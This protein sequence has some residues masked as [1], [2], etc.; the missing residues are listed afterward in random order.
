[1][2]L[3]EALI[4]QEFGKDCIIKAEIDYA[5]IVSSASYKALEQ[6]REILDRDDLDDADCFQRIEEIVRVFEAMGSNGGSR[7]DFG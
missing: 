7:H 1:M 5:Q 6:I 3:Y 4:L 2:E